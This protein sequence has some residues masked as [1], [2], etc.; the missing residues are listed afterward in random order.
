MTKVAR[1]LAVV[2]VVVAAVCGIGVAWEHSSAARWISGPTR[3]T[4]IHR[5]TGVVRRRLQPEGHSQ[6]GFSGP[7]FSDVRNLV[8]TGAVTV[9]IAG[10]V[11]TL[12]RAFR[13]RR[14]RS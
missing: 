13:R 5:P 1:H 12:D 7:N 14:R 9:L 8:T 2:M 10:G 4:P 6:I 3:K 11:V